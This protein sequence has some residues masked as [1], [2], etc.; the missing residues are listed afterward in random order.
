MGMEVEVT[1]HIYSEGLVYSNRLFDIAINLFN[2]N[3][4]E[5]YIE[6]LFPMSE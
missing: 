5:T 3:L 4:L 1:V 6:A 2:F